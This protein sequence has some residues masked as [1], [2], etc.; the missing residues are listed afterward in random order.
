MA[1]PFDIDLEPIVFP[2]RIFPCLRTGHIRFELV[3]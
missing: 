3:L 2:L 1:P